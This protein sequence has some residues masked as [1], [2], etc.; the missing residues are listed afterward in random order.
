MTYG[1][2]HESHLPP[3]ERIAGLLAAA[4]F[5]VTTRLVRDP[6][7]GQQRQQACLLARKPDRAE[8]GGGD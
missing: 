4:G 5:A 8:A 6:G 7:P 1:R 3:P 2:G